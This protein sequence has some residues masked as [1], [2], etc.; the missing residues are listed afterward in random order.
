MI[1]QPVVL[2]YMLLLGRQTDDRIACLIL[3]L[4]LVVTSLFLRGAD[5]ASACCIFFRHSPI[6]S[7]DKNQRL[8]KR[9]AELEQLAGR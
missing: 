6:R 5:A 9:N 1:K 2:S 3:C 7:Q 4:L 8:M